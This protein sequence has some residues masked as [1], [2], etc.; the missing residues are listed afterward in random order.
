ML[1]ALFVFAYGLAAYF[2]GVPL[3]VGLAY[4]AL[5]LITFAVY[6]YDKSAARAKRWRISERTLHAWGL[7]GGWPGALLAQ[8]WIRHKSV[9]PSFRAWFWV[10][11]GLNV[12]AFACLASPIGRTLLGRLTP[13]LA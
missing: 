5:S 3:W 11:A 1:I 7:I 10:T 13:L 9:K 4:V 12:A 8:Q 2:W 6:A